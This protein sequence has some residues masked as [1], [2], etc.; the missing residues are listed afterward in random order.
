MGEFMGEGQTAQ[1]AKHNAAGKALKMLK[2]IPIPDGKSKLD[3]TSQPFTPG[4]EYDDLKSPI[5][6]VQEI[7]LK[8]NL[9]VYF[10][11]VREAGPPHMRTFITKCI[12]GDFLTEGEGNGKKGSKKRAAE[13]ML[14]RLKQ[15]PPVA[16]AQMMKPRKV[17]TGKKKSRNLIKA[18]PKEGIPGAVGLSGSVSGLDTCQTINPIS[19]LIQI[20]QAKKEKEPVYTLIAER[21]MPRRREFV[22]QVSVGHQSTTGTGPNKKLAKRAAAESL[23]QL[24]GYS[25]PSVSIQPGKSAIKTG[26]EAD[27]LEK[28]KKLT[29]VD[30]VGSQLDGLD[31]GSGH[32]SNGNDGHVSH[33]SGGRQLVPGLLYIDDKKPSAQHKTGGSNSSSSS[34]QTVQM[35]GKSV[36]TNGTSGNTQAAT[37]AKELLS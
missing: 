6:L 7:A 19:R 11:V 30:E 34:C 23:L 25:R 17:V 13:L 5:S 10:E 16:S 27:K 35:N 14:D 26:T 22:M 31:L 21:G 20:Q 18:E 8:R 9:Q 29:F 32:A 36:M 4:I 37:I 2:D 3:P 15:L 24:L 12:V 1:A 28:G 33:G